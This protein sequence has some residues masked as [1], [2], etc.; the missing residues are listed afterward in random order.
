MPTNYVKKLL[1]HAA[2]NENPSPVMKMHLD[3]MGWTCFM[4]YKNVVAISTTRDPEQSYQRAALSI[5]TKLLI[6]LVLLTVPVCANVGNHNCTAT[7]DNS[8]DNILP[9]LEF[10]PNYTENITLT[11]D[12]LYGKGFGI[13]YWDDVLRIN[14]TVL[15]NDLF[16]P[17]NAPAHVWASY[18]TNRTDSRQGLIIKVAPGIFDTYPLKEGVA[19]MAHP[20]DF[21][22]H[23]RNYRPLAYIFGSSF[24][25]SSYTLLLYRNATG[26]ANVNSNGKWRIS[27]CRYEVCMQ[28]YYIVGFSNLH[29]LK[30]HLLVH[31]ETDCIV[32]DH[33]IA[34]DDVYPV[35]NT[36]YTQQLIV[37]KNQDGSMT[38]YWGYNGYY[39]GG[40]GYDVAKPFYTFRGDATFTHY[41]VAPMFVLPKSSTNEKET[42]QNLMDVYAA[43]LQR[44]NMLFRFDQRGRIVQFSDCGYSPFN[45]LQC[46]LLDFNPAEGVYNT[47][48]F[49]QTPKKKVVRYSNFTVCDLS[50]LFEYENSNKPPSP[51]D[52]KRISLNDCILPISTLFQQA[53]VFAQTCY[54]LSLSKIQDTCINGLDVDY[55][56]INEADIASLTP[57]AVGPLPAYNYRL[58]KKF[59]GCTM[60]VSANCSDCD[61]E[62]KYVIA[63]YQTTPPCVDVY[64]YCIGPGEHNPYAASYRPLYHIGSDHIA[65]TTRPRTSWQSVHY[66]NVTMKLMAVVLSLREDGAVCGEQ[67]TKVSTNITTGECVEFD[68]LGKTGV[69]IILPS[70]ETYMPF[71]N[72]KL[73]KAGNLIGFKD[74][75]TQDAYHIMP[76]ET[77]AISIVHGPR[78]STAVLYT[79]VSCNAFN[80]KFEHYTEWNRL[81]KDVQG[82][83]TSIGCLFGGVLSNLTTQECDLKVGDGLCAKPVDAAS[84]Y[85]THLIRGSLLDGGLNLTE[86]FEFQNFT[87]GEKHSPFTPNLMDIPINFTMNMHQEYVRVH[88]DKVSVDCAQ[89]VCGSDPTCKQ[90]LIQYGSF[91][92]QI[93]TALATVALEQDNNQ[94]RLFEGLD[95]GRLNTPPL[96]QT[97]FD[98]Y[99]VS[100]LIGCYGSNCEGRQSRSFIEDLLY[101]KVVMAD[102][103]FMQG[104]DKCLKGNSFNDLAC[105]QKFN[106]LTVLPPAMNDVLIGSYTASLLSGTTLAGLG[107]I[108]SAAGAAAQVPFSLQMAYRFNGIAVTQQVLSENQKQIANQ[109][110]HALDLIQKGFDATN[111]ALG[112]IQAAVNQN[113]QALQG[114]IG[115]LSNSF[116]A[117]S[118]AINEIN[119]RLDKIEAEQQIDRLINGRLQALQVYVTQQL[120]RAAEVRASALLAKQ[121]VDECVLG[122]SSRDNFCGEGM[123]L[124]T[125]PQSAPYGLYFIHMTYKPTEYKKFHAVSALCINDTTIVPQS[126]IFVKVNKTTSYYSDE[127]NE[128]WQITERNYFYPVP[129]TTDN[130]K[131]THGCS[132]TTENTTQEIFNPNL[133]NLPNFKDELD[134]WFKNQTTP[135]FTLPELQKL[136]VTILDLRNEMAQLESVIK[137]LNNSYIDLKELGKYEQYQKWPWYIWLIIW[138]ALILLVVI[139]FLLFFLTSC[140]KCLKGCCTCGACCD[141]YDD[142]ELVDKPHYP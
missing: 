51:V 88:M 55:F 121:K 80:Y 137:E 142:Y 3:E 28:P 140:C 133:P 1:K 53:M 100:S 101:N 89:Y 46:S 99:N 115:Q 52:W 116:G 124:M 25:A 49:R 37:K 17:R 8:G 15:V 129:I 26:V 91:C 83:Q 109:F 79:G 92:D 87:L 31:N 54:G 13:Y 6:F 11:Q 21:N 132:Y 72:F 70:N 128:E 68:I 57:D 78:A 67:A 27:V 16:V 96:N 119:Q 22:R 127:S 19:I 77:G 59:D 61:N 110:N 123:H 48:N 95:K 32:K 43:N 138:V 14:Q 102:P 98:D 42:F 47:H 65:D 45:E 69:G 5:C 74:P 106:G 139:I 39:Y 136:N 36:L 120:I 131:Y 130:I 85:N 107:I 97:F 62:L 141:K 135:N 105:A 76:C 29:Q 9:T 23:H 38:F 113:A 82:E 10:D 104:Y 114:L 20:R 93:N 94:M 7:Q 112:K 108:G 18:V 103:G 66:N 40:D 86:L 122:Q 117:I 64:G 33:P 81:T 118:N 90:L 75:L 4:E 56:R 126:G 30:D 71:Q 73:S 84:Y 41:A 12:T 60:A 24:N 34:E 35:M 50:D 125:F 44:I 63:Q 58:S 134:E 2:K 111:S